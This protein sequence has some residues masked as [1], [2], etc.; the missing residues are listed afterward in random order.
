M[1]LSQVLQERESFHR[2]C[3]N[4]AGAYTARR[5]R[6]AAASHNSHPFVHWGVR[7]SGWHTWPMFAEGWLCPE[8]A[9]WG[10][11]WTLGGSLPRMDAPEG[12]FRRGGHEITR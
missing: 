8:D 2:C 12:G 7:P 11:R 10:S 9:A 3:R 6:V 5:P 1:E 4:I